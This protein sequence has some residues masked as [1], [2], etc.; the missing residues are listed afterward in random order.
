MTDLAT[1]INELS[2]TTVTLRLE[3]GIV[4]VA[5]PLAATVGAS[6]VAVSLKKLS[7]Y[8][9]VFG[10]YVAVLIAGADRVCLGKVN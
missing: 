10:D 2:P 8:T 3:Y 4:T 9:P 6:T 5:S 1:A 7:S